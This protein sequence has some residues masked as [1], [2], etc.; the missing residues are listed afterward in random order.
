MTN[1]RA[2]GSF[3]VGIVLLT[4]V[5]SAQ[6]A[7]DYDVPPKALHVTRPAYPQKALEKGVEGTVT[8]DVL[9]DESGRVIRARVTKSIPD[10]DGAAMECVQGWI[11]APARKGGRAVRATAMMPISFRLRDATP[12]TPAPSM[13]SAGSGAV[14]VWL[15][16]EKVPAECDVAPVREELSRQPGISLVKGP[17][18]AVLRLRVTGCVEGPKAAVPT[19]ASALIEH[20]VEAEVTAGAAIDKITGRD[21]HSWQGAANDLAVVVIEWHRRHVGR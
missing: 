8:L 12:V 11:F 9:I 4:G 17:N 15:D 1:L 21:N 13:L 3:G 2:L 20:V 18:E 16:A 5:A 6:P 7:E 14:T 19:P 10:L